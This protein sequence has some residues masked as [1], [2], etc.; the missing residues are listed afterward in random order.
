MNFLFFVFFVF[1]IPSE[2]IQV[3]TCGCK[4][5]DS[6]PGTTTFQPLP[7]L[8][9]SHM[10]GCSPSS[11]WSKVKATIPTVAGLKPLSNRLSDG[12]EEL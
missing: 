4:R 12:E 9:Q 1:V 7:S 8:V 11:G 10:A 2:A 3:L 5:P 6:S